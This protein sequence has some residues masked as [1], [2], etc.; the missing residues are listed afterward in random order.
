MAIVFR[1]LFR[2][3]KRGP[4][5]EAKA[6]QQFECVQDLKRTHSLL[7]KAVL[8]RLASFLAERMM[9]SSGKIE[10]IF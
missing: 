1:I 5:A 10:P 6:G 7:G 8:L 2:H 3:G 9:A 4:S